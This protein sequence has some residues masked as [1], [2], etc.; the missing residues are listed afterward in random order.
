M[1][2][3]IETRLQIFPTIYYM[4]NSDNRARNN[5]HLKFACARIWYM[6]TLLAITFYTSNLTFCDIGFSGIKK[7]HWFIF[8]L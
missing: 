8:L 7:C 6:F 4:P 5:D 1:F 3:A 2:A